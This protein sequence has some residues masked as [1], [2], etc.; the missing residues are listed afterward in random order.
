MLSEIERDALEDIRDNIDRAMRFVR[1]L[2]LETFLVDDKS[3][4]A[5]TRCLEIISEASRRL[6]PVF[7]ER[8]PEIPWKDIAGSGSIYRH[9]Y[10]NILERRIWQTIHEALPPLRAVVAGESEG[11]PP[12]TPATEPP[13]GPRVVS[14]HHSRRRPPWTRKTQTAQP[15]RRK[16]RR[17]H[18]PAS[19]RPRTI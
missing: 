15:M 8:F 18:W 12:I 6:S 2:D 4:Y 17:N 13:L 19:S 10:E 14:Q 5:A 11:D 1:G 9:N 7:K 3:F 16:R